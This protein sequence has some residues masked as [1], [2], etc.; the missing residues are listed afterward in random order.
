MIDCGLRLWSDFPRL[1]TVTDDL[2]SD[3][4]HRPRFKEGLMYRW[5]LCF[6]YLRTRYIASGFDHQRHAG[7]GNT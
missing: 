3:G 7:R 5:L 4:M 2:I 6:R 1:A